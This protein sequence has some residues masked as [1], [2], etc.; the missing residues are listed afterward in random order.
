MLR[1]FASLAAILLAVPMAQA[2]GAPADGA[3]P[4]ALAA[5]VAEL[6]REAE[7]AWGEDREGAEATLREGVALLTALERSP[8]ARSA[9]LERTLGASH[10]LLGDTGP[11]VLHLR[12]AQRLDPA[13]RAI[14]ETLDAAR[15]RVGG[16]PPA[17][18]G[19]RATR[20]VLFW[21]GIVP[22]RA[23][24]LVAVGAWLLAW[25][26]L[27]A[28]RLGA[29]AP[30]A[31]L[32][33]VALLLSLVPA[34]AL[35]SEGVILAVRDDA[36]VVGSGVIARNGPSDDLYPATF[37]EP[38]EPGLEVVVLERRDGWARVRLAS[39]QATWLPQ[40]AI[41]PVTPGAESP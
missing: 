2:R 4:E 22:R 39:G 33:V 24:L 26:L 31:K 11:A 34:G 18:A 16:A 6:V 9:E 15:A 25:A 3:S 30:T 27:L 21:R 38:V 5:R 37:T 23:L 13:S 20:A 10:L 35:A 40:S 17:G 41:E 28:R 8:G 1:Q 29:P 36:V 32:G 12:R 19:E 14:G 7:S